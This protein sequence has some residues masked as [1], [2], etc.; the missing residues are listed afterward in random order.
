M[1]TG[2]THFCSQYIPAMDSQLLKTTGQLINDQNIPINTKWAEI[3]KVLMDHGLLC[4]KVLKP[5]QLLVHPRNRGGGMVFWHDTH[6]KGWK[7]ISTGPCLSKIG[8]SVAMELSSQA[9]TK[10]LQVEKTKP[11]PKPAKAICQLPQAMSSF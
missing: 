2:V 5:A 6:A 11:W 10:K 4:Q 7:S 1:F 8:L 9:G 3:R